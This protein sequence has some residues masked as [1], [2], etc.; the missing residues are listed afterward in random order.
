V[1][2][3][4][5]KRLAL[6]KVCE[7]FPK[8]SKRSACKLLRLHQ[9]TFFYKS[10]RKRSDDELRLAITNLTNGRSQI[11]R[12]M[13]VWRL[14]TRL[15]FKDNH[16]RIA[17]V[18]RDLGLQVGRRKNG[19]RKI[20]SRRFMF[21]AP[22]RPN[23]LWAMDFV[24]DSFA[25]SRKFR[26][27]TVKDLFTHEAIL[28]HVDR[29]IGGD[30]VARELSRIGKVRGLPKAIICD[31]GTEYTSK[32]MDQWS[33]ANKVDLNFIQ[34]GKPI[35]NAF[36]ESFNGKL[37]RECLEQNWFDNL[38]EAK[39]IIEAWRIEY[40]TDRPTKPLGM[41][42]PDEFARQFESAM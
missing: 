32:A 12:P 35:Q 5:S 8:L 38:D 36:I 13:I 14:R 7:N 20:R 27:L 25:N 11:G 18:Y 24:S 31:N 15:G 40:N 22:T 42:T 23:E 17:R 39:E 29:S 30:A 28:L 37:R 10:K 21:I 16:K 19:R 6:T 33:F 2:G 1:V 34:P 4:K 26:V 41:K 3:L 9:S